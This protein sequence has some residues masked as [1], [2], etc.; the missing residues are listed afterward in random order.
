METAN[1]FGDEDRDSINHPFKLMAE[2]THVNQAFS[3]QVLSRTKSPIAYE[4]PNGPFSTSL[5]EVVAPVAYRYRAFTL[6]KP[7]KDGEDDKRV[8]V[9][10][11]CELDGVMRGKQEVRLAPGVVCPMS[12]SVS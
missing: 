10:C 6:G 5:E 7:P 1:D 8:E 3:Q 9:L 2:A 12:V 11:R 4:M